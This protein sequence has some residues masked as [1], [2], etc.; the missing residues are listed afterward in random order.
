M[1]Q[2][3]WVAKKLAAVHM[4][5]GLKTQ[6]SRLKNQEPRTKTQEPKN[7]NPELVT[8]YKDFI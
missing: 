6:D 8:P 3:R 1:K 5:K 7:L 4:G 2:L